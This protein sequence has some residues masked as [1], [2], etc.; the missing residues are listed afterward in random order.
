MSLTGCSGIDSAQQYIQQIQALKANKEQLQN[1]IDSLKKNLSD[2]NNDL[3][4]AQQHIHQA[5]ALKANNEQLQK[6]ID[7]LKNNLSDT[8][9]I[10]KSVHNEVDKLR[11]KNTA[12]EK[13][14]EE[15]IKKFWSMYETDA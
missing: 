2:T 15:R 3:E 9:N 11:K 13:M 4:S 7:S 6:S 10:L 12:L 5:Q 1:M 14:S 8:N